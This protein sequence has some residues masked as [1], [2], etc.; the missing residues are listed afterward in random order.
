MGNAVEID[1]KPNAAAFV[2][3]I[4]QSYITGGMIEEMLRRWMDLGKPLFMIPK[5][6][7]ERILP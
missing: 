4:E 2:Q 6:F 7:R 3:S 1:R 5:D